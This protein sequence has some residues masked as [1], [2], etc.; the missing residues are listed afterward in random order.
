M[1]DSR[2]NRS[3][4]FG[5]KSDVSKN[6]FPLPSC[7]SNCGKRLFRMRLDTVNNE[8]TRALSGEG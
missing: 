5:R 8:N 1:L 7:V 6:N 2:V 3:L 4:A